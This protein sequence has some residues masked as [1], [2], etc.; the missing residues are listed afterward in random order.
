MID[1]KDNE[2]NVK[3]VQDR[4]LRVRAQSRSCLKQHKLKRLS[5]FIDF[6]KHF[7]FC[8]DTFTPRGIVD[9]ELYGALGGGFVEI[10]A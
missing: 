2:G 7:K 10:S 6:K 4:S 8:P 9:T 3:T 5:K 1:V